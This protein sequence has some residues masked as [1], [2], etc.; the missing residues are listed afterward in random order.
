MGLM[1][2]LGMTRRLAA[3]LSGCALFF[4]PVATHAFTPNDPLFQRQWYLRQIKADRAWDITTGSSAVTV[5]VLD[6]GVDG[7][8][9][10]IAGNMWVN[11]DEIPDNQIDDDHNGFVD[12]VRGW[13]FVTGKPN[14]SPMILRD[15]NDEVLAHGTIVSSIIAGKGN[16]GY[17]M[18]GVSWQTKI[19][20]L[21]VLD[22]GGYGNVIDMAKAIRYAVAN[23]ADIINMSLAGYEPDPDLAFALYQASKAGVLVV[24]AAGNDERSPL[25]VDLETEPL[26][27]ACSL[28]GASAIL[29]VSATDALDQKAPYSNYGRSCVGISAPGFEFVA[30]HPI[31][32]GDTASTTAFISGITGTSAAAPLVSGAAALIKSLRPEWKAKQIYQRLVSTADPIEDMQ[33]EEVRGGLGRG[34]LN[35]ERAVSGLARYKFATLFQFFLSL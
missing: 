12:D 24:V 35:V 25:G 1:R 14:T 15:Q 9:P 32:N 30:A 16:D 4:I 13:N 21:V 22:G 31:Q 28:P 29:T 5:A 34:R 26:Y 11:A 27:P 20:P 7:T 3:A 33:Q 2:C 18:A 6:S 19:M 17:G 8:H 10:D 23:G